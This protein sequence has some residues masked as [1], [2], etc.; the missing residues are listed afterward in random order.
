MVVAKMD[1]QENYQ[2]DHMIH[3]LGQKVA[4][5]R[6]VPSPVFPCEHTAALVIG[7]AVGQARRLQWLASVWRLERLCL[8]GE[9]AFPGRLLSVGH[10]AGGHLGGAESPI[11]LGGVL[12][13]CHPGRAGRS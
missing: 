2:E 7:P 1:G 9:F 10:L 6:R 5:R 8:A 3:E 12:L 11:E 13:R 4:A